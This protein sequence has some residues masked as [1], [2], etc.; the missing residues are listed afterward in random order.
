MSF[1]HTTFTLCVETCTSSLF[2]WQ[3]C[4]SAGSS[5]SVPN[6]K[7]RRKFPIRRRRDIHQSNTVFRWLWKL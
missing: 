2:G 7:W 1:I 4:Q 6:E 5:E 3:N